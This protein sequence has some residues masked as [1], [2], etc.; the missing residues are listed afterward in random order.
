MNEYPLFLVKENLYQ[1]KIILKIKI[2]ITGDN[3]SLEMR[4]NKPNAMWATFTSGPLW[5]SDQY[6]Y[7][8]YE[9]YKIYR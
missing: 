6:Y 9:F 1:M 4:R 8:K 3:Y 5:T 7:N 2:K